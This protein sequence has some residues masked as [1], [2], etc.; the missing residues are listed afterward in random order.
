MVNPCPD[1]GLLR[2]FSRIKKEKSK[3]PLLNYIS[4]SINR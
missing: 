2:T 1:A 3:S 4:K